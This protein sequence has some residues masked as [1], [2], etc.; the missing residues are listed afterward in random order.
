M[1]KRLSAGANRVRRAPT[2]QKVSVGLGAA[3]TFLAVGW[4]HRNKK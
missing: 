4:W 3:L 1:N 2:W